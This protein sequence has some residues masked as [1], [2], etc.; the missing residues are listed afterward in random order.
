MKIYLITYDILKESNIKNE[1]VLTEFNNRVKDNKLKKVDHIQ[2]SVLKITTTKD[3]TKLKQIVDNI[4][5]TEN[6][7][8]ITLIDKGA[9]ENNGSVFL[10]L[11]D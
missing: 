11:S 7:Y 3:Y 4:I 6:K 9:I 10:T 2:E 1:T 8:F 5:T